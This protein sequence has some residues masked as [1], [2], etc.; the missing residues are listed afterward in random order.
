MQMAKFTDIPSL[1][2][3][4]WEGAWSRTVDDKYWLIGEKV[5]EVILALVCCM[6]GE[7]S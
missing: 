7:E 4:S 6:A 1:W 3:E 5:E 2:K